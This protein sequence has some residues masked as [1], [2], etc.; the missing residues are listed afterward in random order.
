MQCCTALYSWKIIFE[1]D[2]QLF[3]LILSACSSQE[4]DV[5]KSYLSEISSSVKSQNPADHQ[6]VYPETCSFLWI[7]PRSIGSVF[8]KPGTLTRRISIQRASTVG[9]KTNVHQVII[10]NTHA[11]RETTDLSTSEDGSVNRSQSLLSTNSRITV[12]APKRTERIRMEHDLSKVWTKDLLPYP[13]MGGTRGDHLL[14]ASASS[15]MRK[16][17]RASLTTGFSKRSASHASISSTHSVDMQD[18]PK[19]VIDIENM[20]TLFLRT[21]SE[22]MDQVD[23]VETANHR[24]ISLRKG[25]ASRAPP[26]YIQYVDGNEDTVHVVSAE[27]AKGSKV[28]ELVRNKLA[29]ASK[30]RWTGPFSRIKSLSTDGIKTFRHP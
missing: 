3:E 10:K 24:C 9:S 15:M 5:W 19:L 6:T 21:P 7:K 29:K 22:S 25:S 23:E 2:Q 20:L 13:G 11:L 30:S 28:D 18:L 16:F 27:I 12:L 8:G 1:A 4:E 17:S 14:R 26:K